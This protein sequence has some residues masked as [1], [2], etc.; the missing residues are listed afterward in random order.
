MHYAQNAK[1][2]Y[3]KNLHAGNQELVNAVCQRLLAAINLWL[4]NM[5]DCCHQDNIF[6]PYISPFY[7]FDQSLLSAAG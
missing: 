4:S 6:L 1:Q 2:S 5:S 3:L 7:L